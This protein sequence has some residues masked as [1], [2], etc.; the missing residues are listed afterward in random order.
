MF[1]GTCFNLSCFWFDTF[2]GQEHIIFL[3]FHY[4]KFQNL[5]TSAILFFVCPKLLCVIFVVVVVFLTVVVCVVFLLSV[6]CRFLSLSCECNFVSNFCYLDKSLTSTLTFDPRYCVLAAWHFTNILCC[7][8]KIVD[9]G[10]G[11]VLML[12]HTSTGGWGILN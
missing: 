4:Y 2:N 3:F 9:R 8:F 12:L 1:N 11:R 5:I 6:C 7:Y 10:A